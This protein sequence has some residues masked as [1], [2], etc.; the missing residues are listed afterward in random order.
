M[1]VR[2]PLPKRRA[3]ESFD[4]SITSTPA[5][6]IGLGFYGDGRVGE[7]FI[8]SGKIG[9]AFEAEVSDAAVLISIAFQH[10]LNAAQLYHAMDRTP[11]GR[12]VSVVGHVLAGIINEQ[13]KSEGEASCQH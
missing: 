9:S 13:R 1:P 2:E 4:L 10:G 6:K 3:H 12:P 7:V 11:D 8:T 5:M